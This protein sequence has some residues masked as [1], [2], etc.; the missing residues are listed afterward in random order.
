LPERLWKRGAAKARL[1]V[2]VETSPPKD[3]TG[4]KAAPTPG[5]TLRHVMVTKA[6]ATKQF[7]REHSRR[8]QQQP[9]AAA[10]NSSSN[11]QQLLLCV[12][13]LGGAVALHGAVVSRVALDWPP[14]R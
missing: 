4:I 9:T 5:A 3:T 12:G 11:Q 10:T 7:W 6:V 2:A 13:Q 8:Q 1:G 14:S